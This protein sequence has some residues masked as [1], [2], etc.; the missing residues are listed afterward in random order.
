MSRTK[1]K[2]GVRLG[3]LAGSLLLLGI[4]MAALPPAKPVAVARVMKLKGKV[5]VKDAAG[6]SRA[7]RLYR[8][9]YD[10]EQV[11]VPAGATVVLGF[12]KDRHL[13]QVKASQAVK[14]TAAGC[15][16]ASSV[17]KLAVPGGRKKF[18]S[19]GIARVG[20]Y[21][22]RVGSVVTRSGTR[23]VPPPVTPIATSVVATAKPV[24]SWPAVKSAA[25]YEV[26]VYAARSKSRKWSASTNQTRL[27]YA[28]KG[29]RGALRPGSTYRW[30]LI[31]TGKDKTVKRLYPRQEG[32]KTEA[33]TFTVASRS[34][35]A[36]AGET[37]PLAESKDETFLA[38]AGL[39]YMEN[40]MFADAITANE[41]LVK[42]AP[43]TGLFHAYLA[44]LYETAGHQQKATRSRA[45][46]LD[47]GYIFKEKAPGA[48]EKTRP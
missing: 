4:A 27:A 9:V 22:D 5:M 13:E 30:E 35:Q 24:F 14:V 16:P 40:R 45:R 19:S 12:S 32:K 46:A 23:P 29:R 1:D 7:A 37:R 18:I 25:S 20:K 17:K 36:A 6:K 34:L 44:V 26:V 15:Q 33:L 31:V 39:W 43:E 10:G 3:T 48:T 11:A 2:L 38:L 47:L 21:G 42:L 8:P 41:R 28:G